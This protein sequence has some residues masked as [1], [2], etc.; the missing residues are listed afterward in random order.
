MSF[1]FD[2]PKCLF[3]SNNATH[4]HQSLIM[5][6][7]NPIIIR[8]LHMNAFVWACVYVCQCASV[9]HLEQLRLYVFWLDDTL[10]HTIWWRIY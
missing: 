6:P 8:H 2:M 7:L 9:R 1:M 4:T 10:V 5:N 3:S